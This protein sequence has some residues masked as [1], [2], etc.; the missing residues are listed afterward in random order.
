MQF[1]IPSFNENFLVNLFFA[2]IFLSVCFRDIIFVVGQFIWVKN[3][4]ETL[5]ICHDQG[6]K[7]GYLFYF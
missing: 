7:Q 2:Y 6:I 3:W 4:I 1:F 5:S